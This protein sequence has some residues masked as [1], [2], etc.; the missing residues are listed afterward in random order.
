MGL[1]CCYINVYAAVGLG[2]EVENLPMC[3]PGDCLHFF[4]R[5]IRG[6]GALSQG[7]I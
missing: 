1:N 6:L 5:E 4:R 2:H 3:C 7:Q